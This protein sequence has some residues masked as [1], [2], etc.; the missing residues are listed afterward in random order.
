MRL[1]QI[2]SN[3]KMEEMAP[4]WDIS[5]LTLL[6]IRP[7]PLSELSQFFLHSTLQ[8][9]I[10]LSLLN[11]LVLRALGCRSGRSRWKSHWWQAGLD[12]NANT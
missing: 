5:Q 4:S 12:V 6:V 11:R 3:P 2:F 8:P 1:I 10:V 9:D 7:S